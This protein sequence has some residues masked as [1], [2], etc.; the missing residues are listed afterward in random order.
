VTEAA[1]HYGVS[2]QRIFQWIEEGRLTAYKRGGIYFVM[3]GQ[4]RP[5]DRRRKQQDQ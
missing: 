1:K 5:T 4:P 3:K 2:R